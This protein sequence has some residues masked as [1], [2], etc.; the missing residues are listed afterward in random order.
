MKRSLFKP[1]LVG[2]D[3]LLLLLLPTSVYHKAWF[4]LRSRIVREWQDAHV[5][6]RTKR[7]WLIKYIL[8]PMEIALWVCGW[9]LKKTQGVGEA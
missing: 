9:H 8:G 7:A 2:V 1:P 4:G 5:N 6:G 3:R